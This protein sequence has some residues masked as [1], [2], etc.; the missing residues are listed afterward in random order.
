MINRG[1][2]SYALLPVWMLNTK[3]KDKNYLFAMNG[4]TGKFI[5]E[6]PVD[7]GRLWALFASVAAPVAVVATIALK[8]FL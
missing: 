1:K 6:L 3:F 7:K 4:Q 8:L 2:V 5:G